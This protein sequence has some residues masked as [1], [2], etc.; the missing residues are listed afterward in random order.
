MS[1]LIGQA[2]KDKKLKAPL[3]GIVPWGLVEGRQV[4]CPSQL[5]LLTT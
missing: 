3:I 4:I 2:K 5:K 1:K